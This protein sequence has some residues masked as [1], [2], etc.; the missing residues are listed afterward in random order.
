MGPPAIYAKLAEMPDISS[1]MG[2]PR[3]LP[4]ETPVFRL[5]GR[6]MNHGNPDKSG[7][8]QNRK[9]ENKGGYPILKKTVI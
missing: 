4:R 2:I 1:G 3:D 5:S 9:R 8:H 7:R 6:K